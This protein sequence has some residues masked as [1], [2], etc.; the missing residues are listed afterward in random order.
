VLK[1]GEKKR[2]AIQFSSDVSLSLALV[3]LRFDP[4]VIKINGVSAGTLIG[5]AGAG[6]TFGHSVDAN[7]VCLISLSALN[8]KVSIAGTGDLIFIDVEGIGEGNAALVFDKTTMHL[9]AVDARDVVTQ[10]VQGTATV[11]Q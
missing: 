5:P 7:G 3:G 8:S 10:L 1:V 2:Y 4:K 6:I 11:R 9:V